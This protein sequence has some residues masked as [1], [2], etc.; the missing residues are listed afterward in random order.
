MPF[1]RRV[2]ANILS[3]PRNCLLCRRVQE[4]AWELW[5][6]HLKAAQS[7]PSEAFIQLIRTGHVR[8]V[9]VFFIIER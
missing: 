9:G 3:F 5:E 2:F 7:K 1:V 6:Q 4:L 8:E